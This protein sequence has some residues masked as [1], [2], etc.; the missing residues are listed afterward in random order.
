MNSQD[1]SNKCEPY[2]I[3]YYELFGSI[4]VP[5]DYHATQDEFFAALLKAIEEKKPI[6]EYLSKGAIPE[7]DVVI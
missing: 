2:N 3:K 1:F 6:D 5:W 4:P 7:G